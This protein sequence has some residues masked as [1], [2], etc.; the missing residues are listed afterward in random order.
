[1]LEL[2]SK[3]DAVGEDLRF[4]GRVGAPSLLISEMEISGMG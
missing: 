3:V 2:F 4:L 1:M